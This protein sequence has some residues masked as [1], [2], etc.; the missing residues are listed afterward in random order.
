M[1]FLVL[2]TRITFFSVSCMIKASPLF[3]IHP[4]RTDS[5]N[6]LDNQRQLRMACSREENG[7]FSVNRRSPRGEY[8]AVGSCYDRGADNR[9]RHARN[10]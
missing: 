3:M 4:E 2:N 8:T 5:N 9:R 1:T 7:E 10:L 6:R